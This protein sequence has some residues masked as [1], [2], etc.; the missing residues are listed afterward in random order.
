MNLPKVAVEAAKGAF[1]LTC[2][3]IAC[4]LKMQMSS[5]LASLEAS[6]LVLCL[7]GTLRVA[8]RS[9]RK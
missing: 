8:M 4:R 5:D 2:D 7:Q 3:F 1:S 6:K 9:S